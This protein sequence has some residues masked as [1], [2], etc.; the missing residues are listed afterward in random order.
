MSVV[1][2]LVKKK[3]EQL[4]TI[5][6]LGNFQPVFMLIFGDGNTKRKEHKK[7]PVFFAGISS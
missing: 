6:D 5:F 2:F 7:Y 3:K 4:K 1:G